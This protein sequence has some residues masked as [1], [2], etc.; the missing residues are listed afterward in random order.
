MTRRGF[1]AVAVGGAW[2]AARNWE[3]DAFPGWT[4][5]FVDR[6]LTDSPWARP[7]TAPFRYSAPARPRFL[8]SYF[9]Q[10]GEPLGFPPGWPGRTGTQSGNR[11]PRTE[12]GA[13]PAVLTEIYLTVR[14]AS[15]LPVRQAMALHQYGRGGLDSPRAAALLEGASGEY[16][17]EI[18]GFPATLVGQGA[19]RFEAELLESA[20]LHVK[21]RKALQAV[22]CSM[23]EHGNHLIATLRFP[24]FADLAAEEGMVECSASAGPVAFRQ[25]FKLREMTYGGKLE[26]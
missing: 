17:V 3:R 7:L 24:R 19:R 13:A 16:V 25:R 8:T 21:G 22:A 26:L 12:D 10:I 5:E 9:E 14:W 20:I 11:S 18:A 2:L 1:F 4:E 15:A 23:P 6:I